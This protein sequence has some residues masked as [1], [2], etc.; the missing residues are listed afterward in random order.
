M[1]LVIHVS[2]RQDT[3][4]VITQYR[5]TGHWSPENFSH[6]ATRSPRPIK[7]YAHSVAGHGFKFQGRHPLRHVNKELFWILKFYKIRSAD[8]HQLNCL[9]T[10]WK[11]PAQLF[12]LHCFLFSGDISVIHFLLPGHLGVKTGQAKIRF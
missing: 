4:R 11:Q 5:N 12:K 7:M 6:V 3:S 8:F 9:H 10:S 2:S 1:I